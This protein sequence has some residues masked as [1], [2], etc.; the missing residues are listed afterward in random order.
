MLCGEHPNDLKQWLRCKRSSCMQEVLSR[1]SPLFSLCAP[2][3]LA[4]PLTTSPADA[5]RPRTEALLGGTD[6]DLSS[7]PIALIL[8]KKFLCT[9]LLVGPQQI[10]TAGHCMDASA[11]EYRV[12]V[13]T[14]KFLVDGVFRSAAYDPLGPVTLGTIQYDLG[15]LTLTSPVEEVAPSPILQDLPLRPRDSVTVFGRGTNELPDAIQGLGTGRVG[16]LK[17]ED[18]NGAVIITSTGSADVATC[19]GDSGAPLFRSV[20]GYTVTAGVVSAGTNDADAAGMCR[21]S[22]GGISVFVDLQSP[23]SRSF[24]SQ[25]PEVQYLSGRKVSFLSGVNEL[26]PR[27]TG[28]NVAKN[29]TKLVS[30]F[31]KLRRFADPLRAPILNAVIRSL[32]EASSSRSKP[33][34]LAALQAAASAV[35]E[36]QALGIE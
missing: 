14:K 26:A 30:Q 12:I 22:K 31:T 7:S 27:L 16:N 19:P 1:L 9:G 32:K 21:P 8:T 11:S 23:S 3:L 4:V 33:K 2:L 6:T 28:T 25:F 36:L 5:Q 17:V 29:G 15:M 18:V 35:Q 10:L 24:L 34:K 13:G 20:A